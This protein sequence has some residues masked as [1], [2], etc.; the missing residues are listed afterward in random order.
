MA[1]VVS[2]FDNVTASNDLPY[3]LFEGPRQMVVPV[4]SFVIVS[5]VTVLCGGR[6]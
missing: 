2:I 3:S 5:Y 4:S 1:N 6:G